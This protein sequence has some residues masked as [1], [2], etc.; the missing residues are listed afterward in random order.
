[1]VKA[2]E[3][4]RRKDV[5]VRV[6][7]DGEAIKLGMY[8]TPYDYN[9]NKPY[10]VKTIPSGY[11]IVN[12]MPEAIAAGTDEQKATW[13]A[14]TLAQV[15]VLAGQIYTVRQYTNADGKRDYHYG[16][17]DKASVLAF[18]TSYATAT[19]IKKVD[20]TNLYG[21]L[22]GGGTKGMESDS[23]LTTMDCD[24][25]FA[26]LVL[27]TYDGL[28]YKM[29]GDKVKYVQ[30]DMN[31]YKSAYRYAST[32]WIVS[33]LKGD[34]NHVELNKLFRFH[35]ITDGNNAN[36]EVKVS[37]ENIRPDDGVFDVVVRRVDD[38]DEQIIPLE[39]FG[40]CSMVPGD[41]NYI[42]YKIGSFDGVY[43]SKSKYIT[44]EMPFWIYWKRFIC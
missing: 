10:T 25:R 26:T 31:D 24:S 18:T 16:Y 15:A 44:V 6:L 30:L 20:P 22:K 28:Y 3:T 35:T 33:N 5:G 2:P 29:V 11:T 8:A 17:Y 27:N 41:S 4:L 1:M 36:Y 12:V 40:R 37:I 42:A 34:Y 38:A 43:E 19:P 21:N 13:S 32:P 39:R 7:A 23:N 9:T 14:N